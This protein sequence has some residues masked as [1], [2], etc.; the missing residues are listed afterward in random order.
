MTDE[1]MESVQAFPN[2]LD[3]MAFGKRRSIPPARAG[4][5]DQVLLLRGIPFQAQCDD[6][7]IA[8]TGK[9]SIAYVPSDRVAG[10]STLAQVVEGSA[11]TVCTLEGMAAKIAQF[12]WDHLAPHGVAVVIETEHGGISN[13]DRPLPGVPMVTN[14]MLG[15][16]L[17]EPGGGRKLLSMLG[18]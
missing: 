3:G 12:I 14:R 5:A 8:I 10:I 15:C 2:S 17:E 13:R 9:A 6:P 7:Q 11:H 1:S 18:Y 4:A 16:F